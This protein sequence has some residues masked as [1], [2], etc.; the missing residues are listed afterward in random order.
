MGHS[1]FDRRFSSIRRPRIYATVALI[2]MTVPMSLLIGCGVASQADPS[3]IRLSPLQG[4]MHGGQQP[5]T[6]SQI[7]LYA[8][9]TTGYA[10]SSRSMLT[11]AGYVM[12]D[13]AGN[14]SITGDYTCQSGDLVY[15]VGSGGN[16]G[17]APG[18][19]NTAIQMMAALGPCASLDASTFVN[20]DEVSTI[21]AA[22]ALSPFM[23]DVT[24]V[25]TSSTN[26]L[27]LT[28][29]FATVGNLVDTPTGTALSGTPAGNGVV[30]QAKINTLANIL[31]SCINSD[32]TGTPCGTLMSA[33]TS[34]GHTP[35][36]TLQAAL[37]IAQNP[38]HSLSALYGLQPATAPFQPSLGTVPTDFTLMVTYT[39]S[40]LSLPR[41]IA[42]DSQ[43]NV[44]APSSDD[45][46]RYGCVLKLSLTGKF[47]SGA[48][49]FSGGTLSIVSATPG[50]IAIDLMDNAWISNFSQIGNNVTKLDPGGAI[51][52]GPNGFV[53]DNGTSGPWQIAIDSLDNAW[54]AN[55]DETTVSRLSNSGT[56]LTGSSGFTG[57]MLSTA[58][59]GSGNIWG[60]SWNQFSNPSPIIVKL[61][62][63]GVAQSGAGYP[64]A[65]GSARSFAIDHQGNLWVPLI[66][67]D[68]SSSIIK[69]NNSGT[70]VSGPS[71]YT[72]NSL[73]LPTNAAIDGLGHIWIGNSGGV[74]EMDNNGAFL[75]GP[76]G[77]LNQSTGSGAIAVDGSGN[78]WTSDYVKDRI[79]QLVGVAA[80]VVTPLALGV[81][82]NT[83]GTRP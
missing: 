19:N 9:G 75:S 46:G 25:G 6:G 72:D 61:D 69:M 76:S 64:I 24:H 63:N 18:T 70:V 56:L 73:I 27:G 51:L 47:L 32:G 22:W 45:N 68:F 71:G 21:A 35:S 49:G 37:N 77:Y 54:V 7:F 5:V 30:P 3:P 48:T 16:P 53:I 74:V 82:N 43:G 80:P 52:S 8:A 4:K 67:A 55:P 40:C 20:I 13:A 60:Y 36:D 42:I 50:A 12:T 44:W 2:L 11:G 14:F 62:S 31:S 26:V 1:G 17:L 58:I 57:Y 41:D 29:A 65:R 38:T 78:V 39:G 83:L 28:N 15:L 59:D 34:G 81:K 10:S 23:T 79:E 66:S 33:S